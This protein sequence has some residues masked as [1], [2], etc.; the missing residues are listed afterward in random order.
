MTLSQDNWMVRMPVFNVS[1]IREFIKH[2]TPIYGLP[3]RHHYPSEDVAVTR[4][5]HDIDISENMED[6]SS[7]MFPTIDDLLRGGQS[8]VN[9]PNSS[10]TLDD[11]LDSNNIYTGLTGDSLAFTLVYVSVFTLTLFYV[12]VRLGRRWRKKQ[13][14]I[15]AAQLRNNSVSGDPSP[16]SVSGNVSPALP[17]CGHAQCARAARNATMLPYA[18]LP[19]VAAVH[20]TAACRGRCAACRSMSQPPPSYSKLFLDEQPPA[21]NDSLVI[22]NEEEENSDRDVLVPEDNTTSSILAEANDYNSC[23]VGHDVVI[24]MTDHEE[25]IEDLENPEDQ[26]TLL[27]LP[28]EES[29]NSSNIKI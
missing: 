10:D 29:K 27:N 12:G 15:N 9:V 4:D 22:K 28:E 7:V 19:A 23:D 16:A 11:Q 14:A 26:Q 20:S 21:Y 25:S 2:G 5:Y 1:Q 18:W 3:R 24:D 17:P 13:Q 8:Q 6:E